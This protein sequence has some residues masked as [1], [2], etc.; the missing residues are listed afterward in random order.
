[1]LHNYTEVDLALWLYLE[2]D[3]ALGILLAVLVLPWVVEQLEA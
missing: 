3:V 1:M 2:K